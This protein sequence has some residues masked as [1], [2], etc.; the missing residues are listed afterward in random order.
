MKMLV[1]YPKRTGGVAAL[2][3]GLCLTM[4]SAGAAVL[5]EARVTQVIQDVKLLPSQAAPRPAVPG[6]DV[7]GDTAVRTGVDSRAEL[8]FT[9]LTIARLG[10][11]TIFSFNEGTRTIALSSGAILL[12]VPKGSGGAKVQTAA[13]TAAITGTTV[14]VEYHPNSYAKYIVLEG[15]M[16]LYMKGRLG[17]SILMG[18]GQMMVVRAN[19]TQLSEVVDVDLERLI[20]TSLFFTGFRPLGSENLMADEQRIQLEKKAAGELIDTNLVIFGRGTLVALVDPTHSDTLDLAANARQTPTPT[21]TPQPTATPTPTPQPTATPTP[22]PRP[23]VTPTPTPQPTL[24]PT[25]TPQPTVTPTPT[26]QPTVTPTPTPQPTVT[27]TPT[28]QPTVT[29]T[30][31]PPPTPQ[32]FGTPPVITSKVPYT[33]NA[34][35]IIQTDPIITTGGVEDEGRIYRDATQ[36]GPFSAWAFTATSTFD[37]STGINEFYGA[38]APL[39][40]FKFAGLE[41]SANPTIST[42]NGGATNLALI[43]VGAITSA[44]AGVGSTFTFNGLQSVLIATQNGSIDISG[45]SFDG[46]PSL[47]FYARG[48]GSNLTLNGSVSNVAR[49]RLVAEGAIQIGAAEDLLSGGSGGTLLGTAGGNFTVNAPITATTGPVPGGAEFSGAGGTVSLSSLAGAL[50]VNSTVQVSSADPA[51]P[52]ARRSASG[53]IITLQS[54]LTSGTGITLGMNGNLFSLLDASAPGPGGAITL[55]TNGSNILFQG[56]S[57]RADRGT[58]TIQQTEAPSSGT[59]QITIDGGSI[60]SETAIFS[61]AGD[62]NIGQ[63]TP[64]TLSAVTLSLFA[65]NN[66]DLEGLFTS[67]GAARS[68]GNVTLMAGNDIMIT[69][70][71]GIDRFNLGITD[72]LNILVDAGRTLQSKGSL[73]LSTNGSGLTNGANITVNSGVSM[74][75]AGLVALDTGP[76]EGDQATGTNIKVNAK[77]TATFGGLSAT[78]RNGPGRTLTTGGNIDVSATGAVLAT[79]GEG[80][81]NLEVDNTGPGLIGTG[82]NITLT[83]SGPVTT[84]GA[85]RII[86]AVLNSGGT[87][88]NGGI[89]SASIGGSLNTPLVDA[90]IDNLGG[91]IGTGGS[92]TFGVTGALN[93]SGDASFRILNF[94]SGMPD[95]TITSPTFIK[96]NLADA[97]IGRDLNAYVNNLDAS[98]GPGGDDWTVSLDISGKLI[99]TGRLNVFGTVTSAGTVDAGTLSTTNLIA[100]GSVIARAGGITRFSFPNE[101][102]TNFLHTLTVGSLTSTGGINF[103]GPDL[104]P[105]GA[106]RPN[107]G[108]LTINVASLSF[109]PSLSDNIQG[110]VTFNGGAS[111]STAAAGS[112]GTFT[113]NT[114]GALS[115][116]SPIEATSGLQPNNSEAS[117][118]GGTVNLNSSAGTITVGSRVQVSSADAP[119]GGAPRRRSA[120]GGNIN[121]KS[122]ASGTSASPVV[123]INI[124]N[125]GQLLSLLD[126][127]APGPGGKITILATGA[128]SNINVTGDPGVPVDNIRA[129]RGTAE[130]RH[131]G[132]GGRINL[133]NANIR[134]DVVKVGALGSNGVLTIGGGT[135]TADTILRLYANGSNGQIQFIANVTLDG[136][137][138]KTIAA[139]TVTVFQNV[140]VTIGGGAPAEIY[141]N[142][143]NYSGFNGG[144]GST[145]GIFVLP[146]GGSPVSGANTHLGGTPP[147]FDG[148]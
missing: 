107:G 38:N 139:N 113:V 85:G 108:L 96:I 51:G 6:D 122:G 41:L 142:T 110:P 111:F 147:D 47:Y 19:A 126:A 37:T 103:N 123:A 68:S 13:V 91:R 62:L 14:M 112:G 55:E 10:A 99:V 76:L 33:I 106:G 136:N 34:S 81:I 130:V 109:G 132:N 97:T 29:P 42:A 92:I 120:V 144:N 46:I 141:T 11:N 114:T 25:P 12:R 115:V 24:T 138:V 118:N 32:K 57:L 79:T 58:I 93:T 54:G 77:G 119:A 35:T 67:L 56:G 102:T 105:A 101:I 116:N 5:K 127:V 16:R 64:V 21:P 133:N 31:T 53:G 28:P 59:G 8:T 145:N 2:S 30:P 95:G 87:I 84:G 121:L 73:T 98:I 71:L 80:G 61:S 50:T 117:G 15:T 66:L 82:G 86:L 69:N 124:A 100:P 65:T 131:T 137:S 9:D 63:T 1:A 88:Q 143:A 129:D 148:P 72:G 90:F 7:R 83:L 22:T 18:P 94:Q 135:I 40:A 49:L 48:G 23:T 36:D 17:E 39:A 140:V 128:D 125:T 20:K 104:T 44:P 146:G 26:P 52:G 70:G 75:I 78:V 89:I 27:P 4:A 74:T 3:I 45:I 60:E 43:S 134:A